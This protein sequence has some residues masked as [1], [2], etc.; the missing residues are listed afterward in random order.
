MKITH[1][2]VA[3]PV[4]RLVQTLELDLQFGENGKTRS[5]ST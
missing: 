2:A 1:P 4:F 3:S 5:E